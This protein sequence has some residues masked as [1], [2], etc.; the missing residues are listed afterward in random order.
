MEHIVLHKLVLIVISGILCHWFACRFKI[1]S[2]ALFSIVGLLIGPVFHLVDPSQDF[3][4]L[5]EAIIKLALA[6]I[7]FEGGLNL[8]FHELTHTGKAVKHFILFGLPLSWF[9]GF[10]VCYW[11]ADL[12]FSLSLLISAILVVTG[13]TVILR[14]I[15]QTRLKARTASLLK[16]EGIINDPIGILLAVLVFQFVIASDF[17]ALNKIT[18]LYLLGSIAASILIGFGGAHLLKFTFEK[19]HIPEF[20]KLPVVFATVLSLYAL[21]NLLQEEVGL[22]TVTVMGISMGNIG[23]LIIY[24]L[25]KF[26]ENITAILIPVVFI[27]LTADLNLDNLMGL[28]WRVFGF[29]FGFLFLVRPAAVWL[30]TIGAGLTWQQRL[31]VSWIAPRGIVATSI[32]G[33]LGLKLQERMVDNAELLLPLV[34]VV[35]FSTVLLHGFSIG[36]LARHLG[37]AGNANEGV[38]IVGSHKWSIDLAL[39]LQKE[40]LPVLVVSDSW[41][42]LQQ[43][44]LQGIPI[45]Y[46]EILS[47]SVEEDLELADMGYLLA[48]TG[49]HAYNSLV[50]SVFIQ[51]FGRNRVFQIATNEKKL[52]KKQLNSSFRG[53]VMFG[54]NLIYK[55]LIL[56]YIDGW[57]FQRTRLT[58][59]YDFEALKDNYKG[60]LKPFIRIMNNGELDLDFYEDQSQTNPGETIISFSYKV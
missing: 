32:A 51:H 54:G 37:L 3:G 5:V 40:G 18:V 53:K 26:K 34:F 4:V 23:M 29:L 48:T 9:F 36:W 38:L 30:S 17:I 25:R 7:L 59:E 6:F 10:Q 31:F 57:R 55:E 42:N 11:I 41:K 15:R 19:G 16:W 21:S 58:E 44:R 52:E 49:N 8:K 27:L 46:G 33:L 56:Q 12:F 50:C 39:A 22:L 35:M 24:E 2:I 13:P 20:L 60:R 14:L 47:E 45:H 43:C 1:P 28:N